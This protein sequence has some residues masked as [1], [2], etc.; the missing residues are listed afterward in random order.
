MKYRI[1]HE[2]R[3]Q[4]AEPISVGHNEAWLTPRSTPNQV[5]LSHDLEI[6]PTPSVVISRKDYF[7]NLTTQFAFNQGYGTLA[8][9]ATSQIEVMPPPV[10][11]QRVA[12]E[13]VRDGIRE[14]RNEEEFSSLEFIY[15]SP[16]CRVSPDF[17][18]YARQSFPAG[19]EI[20]ECLADLNR[21]IHADFRYDS[22]ATH[23][24]TPVEHVFRIRK[25]VCQD[26]AHLMISMVR[27]IG[28]PARYVSGYLRTIPPPGQTRLVGADASHAW[29]SVFCG[30]QGWVDLDPTNNSFPSLDHITIAWGRDYSDVS[31]LKGVYIG[32]SSPQLTVSVDVE[33]IPERP[34][35]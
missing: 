19:G 4:C 18:T 27:T 20:R 1:V 5:C 35:T 8:V 17:E 11:S 33:E 9:I 25:G 15:D 30:T 34:L 7:E 13:S 16:R 10:P 29:I 3:Y 28:L 14:W 21:R 6:Q 22:T 32:G 12:W 24:T 23:V 26:F 2:T 31:P